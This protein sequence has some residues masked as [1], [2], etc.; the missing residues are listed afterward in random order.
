HYFGL[1]HPFAREFAAKT[2]AEAYFRLESSHSVPA[3]GDF[4]GDGKADIVSLT[5]GDTGSVTVALSNGTRFVDTGGRWHEVF[6]FGDEIPRVG[7]FNG[8]GKD[9]IVTFTRGSSGRVFVALS[10]GARFVGTAASWHDSFCF[11]NEIPLVGDFNG[12][13]KA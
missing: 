1:P 8:D 11:G 7:D 12:D 5:R 6:C 10:D 2:D 3:V 13:G 9:D 4:N